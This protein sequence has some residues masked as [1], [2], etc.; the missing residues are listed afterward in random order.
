[1]Q[2]TSNDTTRNRVLPYRFVILF[3]YLAVWEGLA[4]WWLWKALVAILLS[5][6]ATPPQLVVLIC[7]LVSADFITGMYA[8]VRTGRKIRS[9][10]MRQTVAKAL[11]YSALLIVF[12]AISNSFEM[13]SWIQSTSYAFVALTEGKSILENLLLK[14]SRAEKVVKKIFDKI[15]DDG[16]DVTDDEIENERLP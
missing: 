7:F 14:G 2:A 13:L 6:F 12:T 4:D 15:R 11:E 5:M 3:R 1:M 10:K 16:Y 9:L 8:A